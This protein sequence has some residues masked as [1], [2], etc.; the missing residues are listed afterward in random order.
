MDLALLLPLKLETEPFP[1]LVPTYALNTGL[2][3]VL[4]EFSFLTHT[5]QVKEN[6]N[7][8]KICVKERRQQGGEAMESS[9]GT[10]C[11]SRLQAGLEGSGGGGVE[12]IYGNKLQMN[13]SSRLEMVFVYAQSIFM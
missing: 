8:R 5:S 11:A 3:S 1:V 6:A 13:C 10:H 9:C 12:G 4:M 7:R 2:Y